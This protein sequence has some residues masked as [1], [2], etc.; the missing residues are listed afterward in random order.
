MDKDLKDPVKVLS[1]L[2]KT[3]TA[4]L[5]HLLGHLAHGFMKQTIFYTLPEIPQFKVI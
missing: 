3:I 5:T 2:A 4:D 1:P